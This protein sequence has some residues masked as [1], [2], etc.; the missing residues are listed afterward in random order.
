MTTESV[1]NA[2]FAIAHR[3]RRPLTELLDRLDDL[4]DAGDKLPKEASDVY[5]AITR[6]LQQ[7]DPVPK[8]VSSDPKD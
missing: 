2:L 5:S 4:A 6:F 1:H 8:I 3:Q 7:Y